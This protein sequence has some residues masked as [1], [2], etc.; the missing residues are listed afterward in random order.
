MQVPYIDCSQFLESSAV[1]RSHTN[2]SPK[3]AFI[4]TSSLIVNTVP[5]CDEN[6]TMLNQLM[7]DL[8]KEASWQ[9][10]TENMHLKP[11]LD[12]AKFVQTYT[13]A[14]QAV[15]TLALIYGVE[16]GTACLFQ[17]QFAKYLRKS[18]L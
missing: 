16:P 1:Q 14:M 8:R 7:K 12:H 9:H 6:T 15:L 2:C 17:Q 18:I 10:D 5:S 3:S 13:D 11:W 4:S